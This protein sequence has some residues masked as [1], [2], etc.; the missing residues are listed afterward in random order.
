[1]IIKTGRF[2]ISTEFLLGTTLLTFIVSPELA[3]PQTPFFQGK[4]VWTIPQRAAGNRPTAAGDRT[5]E[6][7]ARLTVPRQTRRVIFLLQ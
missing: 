3:L 7:Y 6:E 2:N 5:D 4:T 1:M